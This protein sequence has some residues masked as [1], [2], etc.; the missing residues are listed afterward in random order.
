MSFSVQIFEPAVYSLVHFVP[1]LLLALY[2]IRH[3]LRF[4][5]KVTILVIIL[6]SMWQVFLGLAA[7]FSQEN[8][9]LI[10]FS[11]TISYAICYLV[12]VKTSPGKLLFSF[13][14]SATL[15]I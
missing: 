13:C 6:F 4:S 5:K 14:C 3:D 2:P 8:V 11:G 15:P 12:M 1:Y 10:S 7:T 9:G